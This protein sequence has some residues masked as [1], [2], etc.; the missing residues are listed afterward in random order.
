VWGTPTS[1]TE[2]TD[3]QTYQGDGYSIELPQRGYNPTR[4][5]GLAQ[6][7]N[8]DVMWEDAQSTDV[9]TVSVSVFDGKPV[10]SA[11]ELVTLGFMGTDAWDCSIEDNCA[12][13]TGTFQSEQGFSTPS[14][15]AHL[16]ATGKQTDNGVEYVTYDVLTRYADGSQGGRHHLFKIASK[17]G[18]LYVAQFV[19]GEK[20]WAHN[21]PIANLVR[22]SFRVSAFNA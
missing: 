11:K 16:V 20:H 6:Y 12:N 7:P 8:A 3:Y 17:G 21:E 18:K 14:G 2:Y 19:G 22:D 9:A 10:P 15:S 13:A 4:P 1:I 5:G